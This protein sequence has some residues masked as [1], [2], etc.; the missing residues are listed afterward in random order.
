MNLG[1]ANA[2][3]AALENGIKDGM[4]VLNLVVEDELNWDLNGYA[5]STHAFR[6]APR[7]RTQFRGAQL[8][9]HA[10]S[11]GGI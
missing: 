8:G 2:S 6:D 3:T 9:S 7:K 11:A 4:V 10:A 1:S 5:L